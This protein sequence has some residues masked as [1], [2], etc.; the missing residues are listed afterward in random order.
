MG[1]GEVSASDPGAKGGVAVEQPKPDPNTAAPSGV[2]NRRGSCVGIATVPTS[3]QTSVTR[4]AIACLINAERAARGLRPL[5][6]S[7]DLTSAATAHAQDM[8][9]ETYFAHVSPAGETLVDRLRQ[10]G[11]LSAAALKKAEDAAKGAVQ[12][13]QGTVQG[14]QQKA[15]FVAGE[16]LAF[17]TGKAVTARALVR[18]WMA[19][20][21][22]RATL[23]N[24]RVRQL[25]VGIVRGA[26]RASF[27]DD[28][29]TIVTNLGTVTV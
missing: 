15:A 21:S 20:A 27:G 19:N 23:L 29:V 10:A 7:S 28:G 11:Y 22:N 6:L 18:K 17:G 4:K 9:K 12:G 1:S 13:A 2:A 26:P 24:S 14:A 16:T 5:K 8:V 3:S 25:G